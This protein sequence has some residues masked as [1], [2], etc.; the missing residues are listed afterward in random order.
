MSLVKATV[1]V[2]FGRVI[3]L[4]PPDAS[5]AVNIISSL[6]ALDPSKVMLPLANLIELAA[7]AVPDISVVPVT[8]V[9][10]RAVKPAIVEAVAPKLI[11]VLPIVKDELA[12]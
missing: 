2:V 9:D 10:V 8:V 11:D 5:A 1:P 7:S 3:V 4:S 6:S 12:N